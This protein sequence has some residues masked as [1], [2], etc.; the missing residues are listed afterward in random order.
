MITSLAHELE[1]DSETPIPGAKIEAQPRDMKYLARNSLRLR[2]PRSRSPP[3]YF[4]YREGPRLGAPCS[5]CCYEPG[6]PKGFTVAVGQYEGGG[7]G[8]CAYPSS[9]SI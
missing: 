5:V 4:K 3:L 9:I 1:L 8:L 6:S 2:R 7:P